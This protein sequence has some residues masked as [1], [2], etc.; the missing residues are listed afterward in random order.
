MV[1]LTFRQG[2]FYFIK[3]ILIIYKNNN[4]VK[5]FN[6]SFLLIFLSCHDL[7]QWEVPDFLNKIIKD[8]QYIPKEVLVINC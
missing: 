4:V 6:E 5:I 2:R 3:Y 8:K 7:N 1:S